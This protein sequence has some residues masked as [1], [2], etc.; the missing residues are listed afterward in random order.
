MLHEAT[1]PQINNGLAYFCGL[2]LGD[3]CLP[4]AHSL[5]PNGKS[6]KRY[7]ISFYCAS[8]EFLKKIY[9]PLF[10]DLFGIKPKIYIHRVYKKAIVYN[11]RIESKIIYQFLETIG[12]TIGRKARIAKIPKALLNYKLHFLA[13]LLDTD[14]GK[15]GSGFGLST[16]SG[17]LALFCSKT[18]KELNLS[19][20]SCPW[21]YNGHIYHQI[22]VHR[23]DLQKILM[24]IPLKHKD[25]IN[26]IK[27]FASVA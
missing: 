1:L 8:S 27:N 12:L 22:Y 24:H 9:Q 4:R 21:R 20:H 25:K 3:G 5:R 2:I 11:A 14:G 15:K 23:R 19:H 17:N 18:F 13:G 7:I 26:F 16:A 6:Q 10:I